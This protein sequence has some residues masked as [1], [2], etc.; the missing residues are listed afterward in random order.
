MTDD[1]YLVKPLPNEDGKRLYRLEIDEF[2]Q[3]NEMTNL[4]LIA[5]A[6]LQKDSL[7]QLDNKEPD[8][9]TYYNLAG[10]HGE[11][12][13]KWNGYSPT[14]YYGFCHHSKNTFPTWHR[15]YMLL[16]EVGLDPING[17]YH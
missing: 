5:L 10:I 9:L 12:K 7:R 15:P 13:E 17:F 14:E 8:W 16:F 6:A 11:P 2:L 4:F 1:R 3:N